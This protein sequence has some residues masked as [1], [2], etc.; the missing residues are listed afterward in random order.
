MER[1]KIKVKHTRAGII[2]DALVQYAELSTLKFECELKNAEDWEIRFSIA[3]Q[4]HY[5]FKKKFEARYHPQTH[6]VS[7]ELHDA[8]VL[9]SALLDF[10]KTERNDFRRNEME[11][12]KNDLH[13]KRTDLS[14]TVTP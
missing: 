1:L 14:K 13:K 11:I 9:Q 12:V 5:L 6:L 7:L 3:I 10:V 4:L 2:A 8:I